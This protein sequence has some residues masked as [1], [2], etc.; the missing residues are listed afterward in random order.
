M[1]NLRVKI[2]QAANK[3][4]PALSLVVVAMLGM[5]GGVLAANLAITTI[6]SSGE[7]GTLHTNSDKMTVVDNGLGVVA[8]NTNS[9]LTATFPANGLNLNITNGATAGHWFDKITFTD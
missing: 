6:S 7:I 9:V 4:V 3:K 1:S 8:N 5:V 2:S